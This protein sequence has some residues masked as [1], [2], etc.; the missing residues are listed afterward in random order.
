MWQYARKQSLGYVNS[1]ADGGRFAAT[2]TELLG[3]CFRSA[4]LASFEQHSTD[5]AAAQASS[6]AL[7]DGLILGLGLA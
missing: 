2:G 3:A 6:E 4:F 7:V 1:V 5:P